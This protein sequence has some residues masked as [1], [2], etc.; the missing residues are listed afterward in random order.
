MYSF[1]TSHAPYLFFMDWAISTVEPRLNE[2]PRNWQNLFALLR[3]FFF[4][5]LFYY[6]WG[7]E[8]HLF[9]LGPHY[10]EVHYIEVPLCRGDVV[11]SFLETLPKALS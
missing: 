1:F 7:K 9:Y 8:N 4:I 3:L 11:L 5:I 10:V 6:Y 2:G